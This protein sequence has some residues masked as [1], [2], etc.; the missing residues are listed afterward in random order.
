MF[1]LFLLVWFVERE[2]EETPVYPL[3]SAVEFAGT[4]GC[5]GLIVATSLHRQP[6]EKKWFEV[7]LMFFIKRD[8]LSC[9]FFP[10]PELHRKPGGGLDTYRTVNIAVIKYR[11]AHLSRD[12][13]GQDHRPCR[14]ETTGE[15]VRHLVA[16]KCHL[17]KVNNRYSRR[18]STI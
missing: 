16:I 12:Q 9:F 6:R 10:I 14:D 15:V 7:T 17:A 5:V 18:G 3:Y 11:S 2:P 4:L 1:I 8:V 13:M